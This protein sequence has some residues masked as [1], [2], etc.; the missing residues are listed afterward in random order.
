MFRKGDLLRVTAEKIN[1]DGTEPIYYILAT[2]TKDG[3]SLADIR[4]DYSDISIKELRNNFDKYKVEWVR[5]GN[6]I[7]LDRRSSIV[8][9]GS[10][11][12]SPLIELKAGVS[13]HEAF[14]SIDNNVVMLGKLHGIE[15]NGFALNE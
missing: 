8:L 6:R 14:D 13:S 1:N 3:G 5:T 9:S 11:S 7:D 10:G 2:A 12:A 4:I 15:W